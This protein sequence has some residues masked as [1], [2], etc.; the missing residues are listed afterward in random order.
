MPYADLSIIV[1]NYNKGAFIAETLSSILSQS[2]LPSEIIVIDDCSTDSSVCVI[3]KYARRFP[4]VQAYYFHENHGV[5]FA[6]NYGLHKAKSKYVCFVDSDD[7][8]L[9]NDCI[10]Q[11]MR[12]A[13]EDRFVGVYQLCVDAEGLVTT[14]PISKKVKKR[15]ISHYLFN[16]WEMRNFMAWPFHYI[17]AKNAVIKVGGY[18]SFEALYEDAELVIKLVLDGVKPC[19]VD[20]EGKGYRHD[21]VT[22]HL[23]DRK[24]EELNKAKERIKRTYYPAL[25]I[26]TKCFIFLANC[27]REYR[28]MIR[29][30]L[31]RH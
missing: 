22:V 15:F 20:I 8:Y 27:Y 10:K 29:R 13:A 12:F 7:I 4:I 5:Q 30:L 1:P 24:L 6:R 26:R 16:F 19:W 9:R 31:R 23:S 25:P 21:T 14:T 3:D 17:V 28:R 11:Q 18:N 2:L